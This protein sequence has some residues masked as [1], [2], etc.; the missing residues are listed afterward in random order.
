VTADL[1]KEFFS[2]ILSAAQG[3]NPSLGPAVA[4]VQLSG[5][6]KFGFVEFRD[7]VMAAT[8]LQVSRGAVGYRVRLSGRLAAGGAEHLVWG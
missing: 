8:A 4:N 1:V 5:E 3:F 6:G 7:E 2:G